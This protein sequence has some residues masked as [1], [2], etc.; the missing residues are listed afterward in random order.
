MKER[1]PPEGHPISAQKAKELLAGNLVDAYRNIL[2]GCCIPIYWFRLNA[3][4]PEI[5]H[6][7]TL[8][9]VRTPKGLLGI[10]AAHVLQ[11]YKSDS[12]KEPT[13]LQLDNEVVDDLLGRVIDVSDKLD[14]ATIA[15]DEG[16]LNSFGKAITPLNSWPPQ[17]P[18]EGKG[19]MI[20]GYPAIE[21]LQPESLKVNFGLFTVLGM[22]RV[23]TETQ[24]TWLVE[25][26]YQLE[27][28]KIKAP[29]SN[30]NLGGV[31]GG[32][33][34]SWFESANHVTHYRLSGIV[35]E[36]PDYENSDFSIE[37]LIAIRADVVR[38]NGTIR[39]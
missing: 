34:I 4:N 14:L 11:T 18:E 29:P 12:D 10:T 28:A 27:N 20:A 3:K 7:G 16:L 35:T 23:V 37:R 5:L 17:P 38:D 36:H 26:E 31:S 30:Y 1:F 32:P 15:I 8:T 13:R 33:L 39:P 9:L 22:A 24:I 2:K 25:P 21:R 19:I 6:N